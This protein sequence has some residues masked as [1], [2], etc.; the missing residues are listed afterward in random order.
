MKDI[1]K[2]QLAT[3]LRVRDFGAKHPTLFPAGQ[4]AGQLLTAISKAADELNTQE[5]THVASAGQARQNTTSKAAARAALQANLAAINRI[6]NGLA[7]EMI[8]LDNKFRMPRGDDHNLLTAARAYALDALP[9][10]QDF[11][12][13]GLPADFI[14]DLN[15]DIAAFELARAARNES[16][17]KQVASRAALDETL[18]DGLKALKQ[19]DILMRTVLRDD[20]EMQTAWMTASHVERVPH[21]RKQPAAPAE[22]TATN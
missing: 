16:L 17:E 12:R 13:Y 15:T 7:L 21:R 18:A 4:F 9:L 20:V 8:G 3:L 2:N 6:A 5:T 10:K 11:M 14:D 1:E 22:P 19:L